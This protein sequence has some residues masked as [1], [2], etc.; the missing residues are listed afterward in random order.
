MPGPTGRVIRC[1]VTACYGAKGASAK[2]L[3]NT[4]STTSFRNR[5][6]RGGIKT[7]ENHRSSD[8]GHPP[9]DRV[10]RLLVLPFSPKTGICQDH[11]CGGRYS[12]PLIC[13]S[14]STWQGRHN[15]ASGMASRRAGG[16]GWPHCAQTPYPPFS[17]EHSAASID[18][19]LLARASS[20]VAF[21]SR[22]TRPDRLPC[23]RYRPRPGVTLSRSPCP[24]R[25]D[26]ALPPSDCV[27]VP[28]PSAKKAS[29]TS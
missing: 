17:M 15:V 3:Y 11:G 8:Y 16:I 2:I 20:S 13:F 28:S 25:L 24:A 23:D 1:L 21:F 18:C 7:R 29:S 14:F 6:C 19:S 22:R 4:R 5:D 12:P 26:R 27:P 10:E 9:K